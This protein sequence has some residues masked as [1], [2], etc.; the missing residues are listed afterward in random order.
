MRHE[1]L[2]LHRFDRQAAADEDMA[3]I[4]LI[5]ADLPPDLLHHLRIVAE[6][7]SAQALRRSSSG[8]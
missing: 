8:A 5:G 7:L 2:Q 4:M 1:H 6:A 3:R